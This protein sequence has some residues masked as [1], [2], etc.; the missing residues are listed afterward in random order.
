M[1]I[2]IIYFQNEPGIPKV[3]VA[4]IK[5]PENSPELFSE[6]IWKESLEIK[7]LNYR[8]QWLASRLLAQRLTHTDAEIIYTENGKPQLKGSEQDISIS[9]TSTYCAISLDSKPTGIDIEL[10]G[11]KVQRIA[12]KFLNE[13]E[14]EYAID[15][16]T[17]H[18]IWG[19]K[20]S[21]FKAWNKGGVDFRADIL[22][23]PFQPMEEG[24]LEGQFRNSIMSLR[25]K[26]LRDLILVYIS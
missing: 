10:I 12:S 4:E 25:Y 24:V 19:A 11:D 7:S 18:I 21:I 17:Q 9:H 20:E 14:R 8:R 6:D 13:K 22:I 23:H 2:D 26:K 5:E 16:I 1:P 15:S 3:A